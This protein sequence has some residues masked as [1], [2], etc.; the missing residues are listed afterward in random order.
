[1]DQFIA[2]GSD[3]PINDAATLLEAAP[4]AVEVHY[5]DFNRRLRELKRRQRNRRICQLARQGYLNAEIQ[6]K[7]GVSVSTIQRVLQKEDLGQY[8]RPPRAPKRK[9]IPPGG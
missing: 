4:Y 3:E 2:E 8:A 7:V 9:L 5:R 6:R 1:M